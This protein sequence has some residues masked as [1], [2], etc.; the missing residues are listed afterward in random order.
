MIPASGIYTL[1]NLFLLSLGWPCKLALNENNVAKIMGCH[2][3]DYVAKD[4]DFC[5]ASTFLPSLA[6]RACL[7]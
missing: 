3:Q 5:L 2:C 6:L 1:C 7:L 4:G